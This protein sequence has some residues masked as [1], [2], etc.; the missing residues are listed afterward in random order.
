[1][2]VQLP[3]VVPFAHR[4]RHEDGWS[5]HY[6]ALH[7]AAAYAGMTLPEHFEIGAIWQHGCF[8]PWHGVA[9][10]PLV[11]NAPQAQDRPVLVG[12]PDQAALL[13]AAGFKRAQAI[14]LPITYTRPTGVT[15]LPRSLLVMPTHTLTGESYPDR[16]AFAR[17]AEEIHAIAGDFD[18][19]AV[20]VH[21][22]CRRNG[23]WIDEFS[24]YGFAIVDGA[25]VNDR[26]A[27]VR[28]RVLFEQFECV[29]TNG[30]GSHVPYALAFGARLSVHGT[31][32][33]R[34]AEQLSRDSTWSQH[35]GRLNALLADEV[36][37]KQEAFLQR[38]RAAPR[39]GVTDVTTGEALI[40][41]DCRL[42]PEAF[43]KIW[44][45]LVRPAPS[46]LD[47]CRQQLQQAR[48]Q[49]KQLVRQRR[50][51]EAVDLL[52]KLA[53]A[54]AGLKEPHF[55]L[56]T[57]KMVFLDLRSLDPTRAL[58]IKEQADK[59]SAHLKQAA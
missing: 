20:C 37:Q 57:L 4:G 12:R 10:E 35:P 48:A 29:T 50:R 55:L 53:Q 47:L 32:P 44:P 18:Q 17:Y 36:L 33:Q 51:E 14:G 28:M 59:L 31:Q 25:Q 34:G 42:A 58:L 27:L 56:E 54:A 11:Y 6:G 15:R 30:W 43:R 45:A 2:I 19:I 46:P 24:R 23:L 52:L 38:F 40:G 49:A 26:H 39:D 9:A 7:V 41:A 3:D 1:M 22:D 13:R 8:A 5:D 16:T 21:P